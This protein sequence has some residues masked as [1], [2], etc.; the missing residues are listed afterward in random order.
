MILF[1][2]LSCHIQLHYGNQQPNR[3]VVS[4]TKGITRHRG[5]LGRIFTYMT[6]TN[7]QCFMTALIRDIWRSIEPFISPP[8]PKVEYK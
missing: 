1:L 4:V 8:Q 5:G 7:F 6:V 3:S 2:E